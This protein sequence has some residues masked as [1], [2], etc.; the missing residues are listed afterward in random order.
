MSK[1]IRRVPV[2]LDA[3]E[4][5]DLPPEDIQFVFQYLFILGT[6]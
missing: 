4:I 3:G 2:V 5:K 6:F 1:K